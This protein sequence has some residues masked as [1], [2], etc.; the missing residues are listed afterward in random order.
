MPYRDAE[1]Q[2]QYL[3]NHYQKHKEAYKSR[4]QQ[5]K[6]LLREWFNAIKADAKCMI[7]SEN[8]SVCLDYHH[9]D[10]KT[11]VDKISSLVSWMATKEEILA[12]MEKCDVLCSNCHRK[13]H[14]KRQ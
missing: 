5:R 13:L 8:E 12:E 11:K 1:K 9:R 3:V 2:K 6:K 10:A 4:Q 7:C 14:K